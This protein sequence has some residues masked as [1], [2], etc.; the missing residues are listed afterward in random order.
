MLAALA[1]AGCGGDGNEGPGGS[2]GPGSPERSGGSDLA[3]A[4][5][6]ESPAEFV[7]QFE[8]FT[9]I[10]LKPV[11]GDISGIRLEVPLK[12]SRFARFGA[13]ALLWTRDEDSRK[14]LLG[15]GRPDGDGIY[16]QPAGNS[17]TAVKPFGPKL[18]LRWIGRPAKRTTVQWDRLER[19]VEAASGGKASV[20]EPAER[21]CSDVGLDPEEG[22]TGECSVRGIPRTFVDADDELSTPAL[23]AR[24]LGVESAAKLTSPGLAPLVPDGRF[25]IVA[26]RVVNTSSHP[27]RFL[28]PQLSVAGRTVPE[29]PEAAFL[30]PRSRELPLPPGGI[31]EAHTAFD[32]PSS[33]SPEDGAFVL[34]VARNGS[35]D[36]SLELHQGL[37]RVSGAPTRLPKPRASSGARPAGD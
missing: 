9:G 17:F 21:P 23:E 12:P 25:L 14:R 29:Y 30:L 3:D 22:D 10:P 13:Y 32:I 6:A 11:E 33:V 36:P 26:Y 37:I 1:F 4:A 35:D 8:R 5:P 27:I 15:R 20:L 18:V 19:A 7:K 34:P 2:G 31:L 24:V 16:W 28:Q